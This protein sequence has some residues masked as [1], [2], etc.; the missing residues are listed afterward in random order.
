MNEEEISICIR[1]CLEIT[2][3]VLQ[4]TGVGDGE[5]TTA[6]KRRFCQAG[7]DVGFATCG[8]TSG[9]AGCPCRFPEWLYDVCWLSY[10]RGDQGTKLT[11]SSDLDLLDAAELIVECEWGNLGDIRDD[12]QKLLVGRAKVRCMIWDRP[13]D[14]EMIVNWMSES[15]QRYAHSSPDDFYLLAA[16][17]NDGF[18]CWHLRGNGVLVQI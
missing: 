13:Q 4:G 11:D 6:I 14:A 8:T 9:E 17:T 5:W 2:F 10:R 3:D 7:E 18:L 15:V 12:F 1:E 16:Y